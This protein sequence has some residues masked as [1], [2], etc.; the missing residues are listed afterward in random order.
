MINLPNFLTAFTQSIMKKRNW[1][2]YESKVQSFHFDNEP[3]LIH[4]IKSGT[5]NSYI[6]VYE[7]GYQLQTGN[8][9]ILTKEMIEERFNILLTI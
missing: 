6:L 8:T 4:I 9:E 3:E 2:E 5:P 1:Y 7:D